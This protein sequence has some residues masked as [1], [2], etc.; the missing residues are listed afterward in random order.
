STVPQGVCPSEKKSAGEPGCGID[1]W[2]ATAATPSQRC[3]QGK[4]RM[5][6]HEG[7]NSGH[8]G[9]QLAHHP[10][11]FVVKGAAAALEPWLFGFGERRG[12]AGRDDQK[13]DV[14]E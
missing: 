10:A 13:V 11:P 7:I 12:L 4:G 8:V 14:I 6:E 3:D 9:T 2:T 1:R 5:H